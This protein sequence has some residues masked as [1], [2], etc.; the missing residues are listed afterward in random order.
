MK[1]KH[2][3]K[4]IFFISIALVFFVLSGCML[5]TNGSD[6]NDDYSDILSYNFYF[7]QLHSHTNLSDGQGTPE[8]AYEWARDMANLDFFAVTD[9]SN[10]FDNDTDRDNETIT[11]V[12][13]S[14]SEK[15]KRL[16]AVADEFNE[17]GRFVAIA[18]FE[19]TWS[20][21]TG[22]W[23]H[24]NT[25]N[26]PWF[27][28][29]DVPEMDLIT[30]Y[31]LLAQSPDS[32]SQ[33]NHPGE[34][35]GDFNDFSYYKPEFDDVIHLIEVGNGEGPVGG[36]GY[37][38]S[39]EYYTRALDKGWHVAPSNNQD[40]HRREWGTANDARTVVLAP[41]LSRESI[42]DAIRNYR[43]YAT[44]DKNLEITYIVNDEIMGSI[45]ENP[46]NLRIHISAVDPDESDSI[47][48]VSLIANGGIEVESKSFD[49][50]E[51]LWNLELKPLYDYYYVR[52]EQEDGDIAVTAPV[53]TGEVVRAG[54]SKLEVSP[55]IQIIGENVEIKVTLY[56][57]TL[58]DFENVVV[59]FYKDQISPENKIG[60]KTINII[61][62]AGIGEVSFEWSSSIEGDYTIYA[63]SEIMIDGI[64]REFTEEVTVSFRDEENATKIIL[65]ASHF[66]D[67]VSGYY[68]DNYSA[69][70]QMI[71]EEGY[72]FIVN[73]ERISDD[74]LKNT[75]V[76]IIT[77][78]DRLGDN[79][80][81]FAQ[82]ELEAIA[83]YTEEGG[84]LIVAGRADYKDGEGEFQTS[85]QINNILETI[86]SSLRINDDQVVDYDNNGGQP[87]RLYFDD[88]VSSKYY[89]T[90]NIPEE[91]TY[92]FYSGCSVILEGESD[93]NVD[94]LV[95]GH[96]TT[97]TSDADNKGDNTPVDQGEVYVLAAEELESGAKIVVAG[98]IFFSDFETAGQ[99][100]DFYSN[101]LITENII[102]WMT[103][104]LMD[105]SEVRKDENNDGI[106]DLLGE[107]VMIEGRTTTYSPAIDN[108]SDNAFFDVIYAQ[109]ET[110][111][112]C[113]F[114]VSQI[115]LELGVK[116]RVIG[117][118]DHYLGEFEV[119]IEDENKDIIIIDEN[120]A[121]VLPL[122]ISTGD[123]MK[124]EYQGWLIKVEGTV[125]RMTE[126]SLYLNDGT[127]EAR[128]YVEGYIGDGTGNEEML[129]KW[130]PS[131]E[132]GDTV[133]AIGIASKDPQGPRLRVRN[134]AEIVKIE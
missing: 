129:G 33:W 17:D 105:I 59:E 117:T 81:V 44:E 75:D 29:R 108:P 114:G 56:N 27:A 132:I 63:R 69:L 26:T 85:T 98:S 37:F 130:D 15:W 118:V 80:S 83:R 134:T 10:W 7:G 1:G 67:Y 79:R 51:I 92:S 21:S 82:D 53:W 23:G 39:Y 103:I 58:Q 96:S 8:E 109:D 124:D 49:S 91:K 13:Q 111:G 104:D 84:N 116:I 125:T 38:R 72:I 2:L 36:P 90:N 62:S 66:N 127:G 31:E 123:S 94:W 121:E 46:Q 4:S 65:D 35:F 122:E 50:N 128:V 100:A 41:E 133:S 77:G 112:I 107:K 115:P 61:E 19:M 43:V 71:E 22:G 74:L 95:K 70:Q 68:A 101:K 73:E 12:E 120:P 6:S 60:E 30:Y 28:S 52:I 40:N 11:D 14:T 32:I 45:L 18:G 76:L 3:K 54:I 9:H 16:N 48:K 24:I 34:T 106:P 126:S 119:Q 88:Y 42:Y 78:P 113:V 99:S 131:I 20:G 47:T 64:P 55:R 93:E 25:F 110:G 86:G 102:N 57:N 97:E 89:L 87:W 5:F